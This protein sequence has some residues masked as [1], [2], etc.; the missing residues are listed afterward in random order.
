MMERL[1]PLLERVTDEE[2]AAIQRALPAPG[3]VLADVG[4]EPD[5][6]R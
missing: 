3:R 4:D 6:K 5:D 1:V 2:M